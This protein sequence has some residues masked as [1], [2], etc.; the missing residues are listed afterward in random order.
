MNKLFGTSGIR[1]RI[2]EYPKGFAYDL[3]AS[4]GTLTKGKIA[5]GRDTRASGPVFE[6]EF[7]AGLNSTGLDAVSLG[8]TPTPTLGVAT[9]VYGIGVEITA[10][11]NPPDY[12]GFKFFDKFG[13]FEPDAENKLEEILAKK[14]FKTG[15][16]TSFSEDFSQ[17]HID[18]IIKVTGHFN[19]L[20]VFVD[21]AGG[22][23]S[24][25]TPKMLEETGCIF[26]TINTN[27]DGVFPHGLEP[28]EKNL[29]TTCRQVAKSDIDIAFAHDGDADR[30]CAIGADG[31]LIEWDSFLTALASKSKKAV[32]TVDASMRI[33]EYCQKVYRVAVGDVAVVEGIRKYEAGFGG[34]PSGT[35][36]F[37]D[38]HIYPDGV[39][40]IAKTLQMVADD[41]FYD[42]IKDIP[43]YPM[44]RVKIPC[45]HNEKISIMEK[46]VDVVEGENI[47]DIDGV[48]IERDWGWVLIRPSGTED[49]IRITAEA[50]D[51]NR[52]AELVKQ[53]KQWIKDCN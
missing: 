27:T 28:T 19:E 8:I 35:Y 30:T 3:G 37:P 34:E 11:H 39:A 13:A 36:I 25:V 47:S 40:T 32:T 43:S 5:V 31:K 1:K 42:L 51:E 53:G 15:S 44:E 9:S 20:K 50:K 10:S 6:K 21:C 41:S 29:E 18:K 4:L 14:K 22:A 16:G 38:I 17:T 26:Q 12:N 33:E 23:G 2:T 52:L 48:R 7:I 45:T 46:I 49:F 24:T